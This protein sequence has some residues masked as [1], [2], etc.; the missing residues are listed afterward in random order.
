[1]PNKST[2]EKPMQTAPLDPE[3]LRELT[4][5]VVHA[6]GDRYIYRDPRVIGVRLLAALIDAGM[7]VR[8][9]DDWAYDCY[10]A[11]DAGRRVVE[12]SE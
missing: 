2:T 3:A 4:C 12:A 8:A 6:G 5:I 10:R 11:T 1:M 9:G 7:I